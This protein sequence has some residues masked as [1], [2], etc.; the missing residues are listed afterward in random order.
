MIVHLILILFCPKLAPHSFIFISL[1]FVYYT[2]SFFRDIVVRCLEGGCNDYIPPTYRPDF[3]RVPMRIIGLSPTRSLSFL[4]YL[5]L[6]VV[7]PSHETIYVSWY[8]ERPFVDCPSSEY[9]YVLPRLLVFLSCAET[10]LEDAYQ[11][12]RAAF[13][14]NT[15]Q[16][17]SLNTENC[18]WDERILIFC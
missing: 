10:T 14:T 17:D 7:V 2:L 13:V 16:Q 9:H 4:R 12:L 11:P 18:F 5:P 6:L 3:R 8:V 1:I 15:F